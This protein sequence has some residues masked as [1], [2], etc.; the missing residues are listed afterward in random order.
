M[1]FRLQWSRRRCLLSV[2]QAMNY[3]NDFVVQEEK[4]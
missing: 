2:S 4:P 3:S 1:A